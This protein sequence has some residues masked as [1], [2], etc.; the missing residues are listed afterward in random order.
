MPRES[1]ALIRQLDSS[2]VCVRYHLL[3]TQNERLLPCSSPVERSQIAAGV[4]DVRQKQN[5]TY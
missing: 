1:P 2:A 4:V 3:T 5:Q